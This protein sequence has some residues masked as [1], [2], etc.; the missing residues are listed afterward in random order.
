MS[1][2]KRLFGGGDD[3]EQ[4]QP[5]RIVQSGSRSRNMTDQQAIERYQYMLRTAPPETIEQAHAEAFAKLTPEQRRMVLQELSTQVPESERA[6]SDDPQSL[7]RM[8]TRA[9]M[10]QPGMMQRTFGGMGGGMGGMGMGGMGMG[11]GGTIMTSLA[12][13][14]VGSMVAQSFMDSMGGFDGVGEGGFD[15]GDAGAD[16]GGADGG[17]A[18]VGYGE[19]TGGLTR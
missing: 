10:R 11:I 12:A 6:T 7:A 13:G 1:F 16:A 3:E 9:E 18:E 8:A 4:Q 14:F 19:D 5:R 15:G 2:L 17:G